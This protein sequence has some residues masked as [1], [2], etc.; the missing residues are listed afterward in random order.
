MEDNNLRTSR[1]L[2]GGRLFSVIFLVCLVQIVPLPAASTSDSRRRE[3]ADE[4]RADE[5]SERQRPVTV[6]DAIR[7]TKI[8][9]P[10]YYRGAPSS[11]RVAQFSPDRKKF[12]VILRKGN[13]TKNSNDYSLLFWQTTAAL[14]SSVPQVLLTRSS[15]SNLEAIADVRWLQDNETILFLG[16]DLGET[17]QLYTLNTRSHLLKKLTNHPTNVISYSVSKTGNQIAYVAERPFE[18][19]WNDESR[20]HGVVV[21]KQWISDLITGRDGYD[22]RAAEGELFFLN[23]NGSHRLKVPGAIHLSLSKPYLSPDGRFI[24]LATEVATIPEGWKHYQDDYLQGS[25]RATESA[26][27]S[28]LLQYELLDTVT[29]R[30]RVLLDSP[31]QFAQVV[32][33]PNGG[34][35]ILCHV[36]LPLEQVSPEE[37]KVRAARTFTVEVEVGDSKLT[38]I[39]EGQTTTA[40][41]WDEGA[42]QLVLETRTS[43]WASRLYFRKNDGQWEKQDDNSSLAENRAEVIVDEGMNTTPKLFIRDPKT[44]HETLLLDLNPQFKEL[45]FTKVEEVRWRRSDG[46][47]AVG[48]LYYPADYIPGKRYPLVVQMHGWDP[49]RFW[50]DGPSTTAFAAQPLT[51]KGI[52]VLQADDAPLEVG[53]QGHEVMAEIAII[54]SAL[55]YLDKAGLID[56]SRVGL[57]GWSRSSFFVKYALTRSEYRFVAAAV[58][59][60]EDGGYLQYITNN[61][62]FV[63]SDSLYGGP[64]FGDALKKWMSISPG[65]NVDRVNTPMRITVLNARLLLLDWE[66]FE[67]LRR[68]GKPVEMVMMQDGSHLL[69]KPWERLVSQQGNVDW[70]VFWLKG[71]EDPDRA[72]AEQYARWREL[73]KLQEHN[74]AKSKETNS[75][76]PN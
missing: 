52:M 72:K 38:K 5:D 66:W 19:L 70:F 3:V 8:G 63:D 61:N 75:A 42:N 33:M 49:N 48:G 55:R 57:L 16:G 32:W 60:G 59:E 39:S 28:D 64:P 26:P 74:E 71:E 10:A 35:V 67:A 41:S 27:V 1:H 25:I 22:Y 62:F 20:R 54:E 13:L 11:G 23:G 45:R 68:L 15:A 29:G 46:A 12:V 51:S 50:I 30:S 21:S 43:A 69:Q 40:A 56:I 53:Q 14:R 17:R 76:P 73:R 4:K 37:L 34:S 47:D 9:N 44:E 24:V 65:F 58:S 7:M 36:F 18:S 6:A 31:A 2:C